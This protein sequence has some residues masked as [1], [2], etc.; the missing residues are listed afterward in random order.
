MIIV[1]DEGKA[2]DIG[3]W[4]LQNAGHPS[5]VQW[6]SWP[7][8][9]F[10]VPADLAHQFHKLHKGEEPE[11]PQDQAQA[12]DQ[13]PKRRGRPRKNPEPVPGTDDT[14]KEE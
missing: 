10:K 3:Q 1:P 12:A 4:L 11:E 8:A 2:R 6:V 7:E 9:G 14:E 5:H 13:A